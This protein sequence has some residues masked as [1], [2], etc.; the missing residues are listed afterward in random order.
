MFT[1]TVPL[2]ALDGKTVKEIQ[3]VLDGFK[4]ASAEGPVRG[5]VAS[6]GDASAYAL[7]WEWGNARQ[8]KKGPKT[9]KGI[10]PDGKSVWLSIQAPSGYIRIHEDDYIAILQKELA[11]TDFSGVDAKSIRLS[12]ELAAS[13][14]AEKMA[15]LIRQTVPVDSGDLR[16][17]IVAMDPDDSALDAKDDSLE[18]EP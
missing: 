14:A 6:E 1:V 10:N 17:S 9:V 16:D 5:G 18:L 7:V 12:M 8:T 15:D 13:R 2:P 4:N 11:D 3:K